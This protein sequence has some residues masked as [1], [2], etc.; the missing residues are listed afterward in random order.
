MPNTTGFH[1]FPLT[2]PFP[3]TERRLHIQYLYD[4]VFL[5]GAR[6]CVEM[7]IDVVKLHKIA[8]HVANIYTA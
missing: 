8:G 1:E 6:V 3:Q 7:P 4:D 5:N 2:P